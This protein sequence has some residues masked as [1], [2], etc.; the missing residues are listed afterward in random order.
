[1]V[2]LTFQ[3]PHDVL[4]ISSCDQ[5]VSSDTTTRVGTRARAHAQSATTVNGH[6]QASNT[7]GLDWRRYRTRGNSALRSRLTFKSTK[8]MPDIKAAM[9][10]PL[11]VSR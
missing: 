10:S 5:V 8:R 11:A 1:M 6:M 3:R 7:A 9:K 4:A 2:L